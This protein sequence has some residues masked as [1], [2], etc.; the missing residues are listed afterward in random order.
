MQCE[1]GLLMARFIVFILITSRFKHQYS[2]QLFFIVLKV[3]RAQ[4]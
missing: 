4:K 3:N 2:C 1:K